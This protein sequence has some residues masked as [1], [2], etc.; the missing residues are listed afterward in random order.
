MKKIFR[1]VS[2]LILS[3]VTPVFSQLSVVSSYPTHG[4]INV[5]TA[6][7]FVL[8][9]N[10][11]LDTSARFEYPGDFFLNL[12]FYPDSLIGE[13]DS[14]V[15]S[16]DLMTVNVYNLHLEF[17]TTYLFTL[18]DAVST[19]EDSLAQPYSM[20]FTTAS[21]LATADVSGS[22]SYPGHDPEGTWVAILNDYPFKE[23]GGSPVNGIVIPPSSD[24]YT[25]NYVDTG[26][27][28]VGG[29]KNFH[30]GEE[31]NPMI[32]EGT[33]VGFLDADNDYIVDSIYVSLSSH[34]TGI[35]FTL[36]TAILQTA[37]E[38]LT[39]VGNAV[40]SWAT[41]AFLV[42]VLSEVNSDGNSTGW[43]YI[44]YSP[45]LAERTSWLNVGDL[46]V[47]GVPDE[48]PSDTVEVPTNWV[49]SDL[50]LGIAESQGGSD[51]RQAYPDAEI[52]SLLGQFSIEYSSPKLNLLN[53]KRNL[54]NTFFNYLRFNHIITKNAM[55]GFNLLDNINGLTSF[56]WVVQY[57]SP[58][59][60][61]YL[62]FIMDPVS[63]EILNTSSTATDAEEAVPEGERDT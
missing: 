46:V 39:L 60:D 61:E 9:F 5:D 45:S 40:R 8:N 35:D 38:P 34:I 6:A 30:V 57:Y 50:I 24:S 62:L 54:N 17:N 36:H 20:T 41:D 2:V 42:R 26:W 28:W 49:D 21:V 56:V 43:E 33:G 47:R 15:L 29:I 31:I 63:G 16:T 19:S 27:Y 32:E 18:V 7:T 1:M 52:R 58:E 37:K 12:Y 25:I 3:I 48:F 23:R 10:E 14:I 44:F 55:S 4:D 22:L 13:P 51:F 59:Y 53:S 11:P